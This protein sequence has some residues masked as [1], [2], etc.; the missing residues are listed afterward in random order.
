MSRNDV[1][2]FFA[3]LYQSLKSELL[4]PT[5]DLESYCDFME[6]FLDEIEINGI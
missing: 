2:N 3:R 4:V 6:P 5:R 1:F